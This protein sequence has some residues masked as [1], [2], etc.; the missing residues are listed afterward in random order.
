M[1]RLTLRFYRLALAVTLTTLTTVAVNGQST[2]AQSSADSSSAALPTSKSAQPVPD[3]SAAYFHAALAGSYE[4]QAAMLGRPDLLT[5]ATE[6]YK[7]ALASDPTSPSLNLALANL[8]FR[9]GHNREAEQTARELIK[10]APENIEAHRLLGHVLVRRLSESESS[11]DAAVEQAITEYEK[12]IKLEDKKAE[13]RMILGQLYGVHR[14]TKKA[15][16]QFREALALEPDSEEIVLNLARLY[17]EGNDLQSA[18][19]TIEAVSP[20]SRS[21][22]MELV[23]AAS[24][25]QLKKTPLAIAAFRRAVELEPGD[26]HTV[27]LLAQALY[28]SNQ[29]DDALTQYRSLTDLDPE[30]GE[31]WIRIGEILRRQSKYEDALSAIRKGRSKDPGNREAWQLEAGYNEG[32]LLDVLG[33]YDEAITV[34]EQ[35]VDQTSHANGA[36]TADERNNRSIFLERLGSVYREQNNIPKAAATF[37]KV[38]DMGGDQAVNGYRGLISV[39]IGA[40]DFEH[41]VEAARKGVAAF[42]KNSELK[43]SLAD[44][45]TDLGKIDEAI[46]TAHS[47]IQSNPTDRTSLIGLA[48]LCVR[49]RRWKDAEDAL[50]SATALTT[51]KED[52]LTLLFLKGE[53]AERQKRFEEAEKYFHQLLE[54]EPTNAPALNYLGYMLADKTPRAAEAIKLIR[55]AVEIEPMDGA[56]LDS[57]GWAYYKLGQYELAEENLLHAIERDRTDPTVHDHLGE[58]YEKTGRIRLAAAQWEISISLYSKASPVDIEPG[59]VARVQH[60]LDSAKVK[61]AHQQSAIGEQKKP[62]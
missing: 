48:Q 7:A 8:Y 50:N 35:M 21:P 13:N 61:I 20:D 38:I 34:F 3:R 6:E 46:S 59:E 5:Q 45:L 49:V 16:E 52:K 43:L 4:E 33:R 10:T 1:E 27:S 37:Q 9:S 58:V 32:L 54:L 51:S 22:R 23:L 25:E 14:E 40:K 18:I 19:K 53:I 11:T 31:A 28:N 12:L 55:K 2:T 36:Y 62:Q 17:A 60:K 56:F 24:Y 57:L 39:Y 29:F 44:A 42:P 30:N 26:A 47:L 41:S 15:E